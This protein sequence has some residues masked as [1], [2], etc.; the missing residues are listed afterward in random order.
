MLASPVATLTVL[1][2]FLVQKYEPRVA[3]NM[4]PETRVGPVWICRRL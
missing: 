1:P 2:P 4:S 3:A